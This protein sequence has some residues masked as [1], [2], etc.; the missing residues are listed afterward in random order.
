[1]TSISIVT[2]ILN[3]RQDVQFL[4]QSI[5]NQ[6]NPNWKWVISDGYSTDGSFEYLNELAIND[7]RIKVVRN[8]DFSV[9]HAFNLALKHCDT[10]YYIPAGSD[11][12][13]S[14]DCVDVFYKAIEYSNKSDIIASGIKVGSN[15]LFPNNLPS[16]ISIHSHISHHSIATM[17]KL[18]L[19]HKYGFYSKRFHI[20][21]DQ[22]FLKKAI[23]GGATYYRIENY[24]A[25][26]YGIAGQSSV[27]VIGT[28]TELFRINLEVEGHKFLTYLLF[29]ARLLKNVSLIIKK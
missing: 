17:I 12:V 3:N 15:S 24:I 13:F 19:H 7:D 25:G 22:Y 28:I 23:K 2:V 29:L 9:F 18:N 27:D 16:V 6:T 26:N 10:E 1:M 11:D 5:L 21:A 14:L 8:H 20:A 4:A